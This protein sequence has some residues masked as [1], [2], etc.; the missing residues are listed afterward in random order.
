[1]KWEAKTVEVSLDILRKSSSPDAAVKLISKAFGEEIS[2]NA[3]RKALLKHKGL[4]PKDVL[5]QANQMLEIDSIVSH[6]NTKSKKH[7]K[8][9]EGLCN[10]FNKSP[11][12]IKNLLEQARSLGYR[13]D[14]VDDK[15]FLDKVV[16]RDTKEAHVP[17]SIS[18]ERSIKFAVISDTHFGSQAARPD[19]VEDFVNFAYAQG[20]RVILHAGDIIT[21]NS[22]Y[23]NQV[24]ELSH[25]GCHAQCLEA[26]KGLPQKDGLRYY[27]ILGNHDLN[28]V[29]TAGVDPGLILESMRP[30]IKIVG[31]LKGNVLLQPENILIEMIHVKSHASGLSYPLEKHIAKAVSKGF[32]PDIILAGHLHRQG[33]FMLNGIH[34]FLLPC[35]EDENTFVKYHDFVPVIGGLILTLE[36]N[37]ANKPVECITHVKYY[38]TKT[39]TATPISL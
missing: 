27:G 12:Y 25:W 3:L 18:K 23:R 22:V 11:Q 1:M 21:G 2:W 13:F 24:A 30:D 32:L 37:A 10:F 8:S 15:I 4:S 20:V 9:L 5:N 16:D 29:T 26:C 34:S 19:L 38:N 33:S 35:F 7:N 36:L 6:L 17:I 39:P 31:H 28:F 14:L